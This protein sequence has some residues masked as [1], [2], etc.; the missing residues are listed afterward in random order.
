MV[1]A[2]VTGG[3]AFGSTVVSVQCMRSIVPGNQLFGEGLE[4]S[5]IAVEMKQGGCLGYISLDTPP[6][7][8]CGVES[9]R[10]VILHVGGLHQRSVE[11]QRYSRIAQHIQ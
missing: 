6:S 5:L 10:R 11:V 9:I 8:H 4:G 7:A 1:E 2:L 3:I